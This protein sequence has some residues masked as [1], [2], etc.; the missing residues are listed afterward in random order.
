[1]TFFFYLWTKCF[2]TFTPGCW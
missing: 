1:V 2:H